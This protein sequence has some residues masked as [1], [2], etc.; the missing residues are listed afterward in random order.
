MPVSQRVIAAYL[1]Q[2]GSVGGVAATPPANTVAPVVTGT[3]TVGQTLSTTDGTW[4]GTATITYTYQWQRAGVNIGSATSSTYL[5]VDADYAS[6]IRCV[7]TG[8]NAG[9]SA[10]ANSNATAAVVRTYPQEV[11]ADTPR[12]YWKFTEPSGTSIADSSGNSLTLTTH[13]SPTLGVTGPRTG[14]TACFFASGS[15][16]YADRADN[17]LLDLADTFTIECF[18]KRGSVVGT[19]QYIIS[20]GANAYGMLMYDTNVVQGQ[21][22]AVQNVAN[23]SSTIGNDSTWHHIAFTKTGTTRKIY[24]D[25]ADVTSLGTNGT[26]TDNATSL[27]IGGKSDLT[28]FLEGTLAHVAVYPTA[29]SAARI[30][31]HYGAR[32]R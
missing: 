10:S 17:N 24:V 26:G 19:F 29:L 12:G 14:E 7:V 23:S 3:A 18:Y 32:A 4:T 31:A 30:T 20:K 28:S 2:R 21:I 11:L 1:S 25:G 15:S 22:Q 27:F 9:G 8:T 16:Q 5:L 6:A 13:N